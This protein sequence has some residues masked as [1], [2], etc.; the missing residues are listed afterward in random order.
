M[1][2][3]LVLLAPPHTSFLSRILLSLFSPTSLHH[4]SRLD[5]RTLLG[6]QSIFSSLIVRPDDRGHYRDRPFLGEI[7]V[8]NN[9]RSEVSA[10]RLPDI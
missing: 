3:P 2:G 7:Q 8:T 5:P 9:E 10:S 1:G 6:M 4:T